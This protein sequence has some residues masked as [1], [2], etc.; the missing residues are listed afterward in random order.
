MS[1][2]FVLKTHQWHMVF[3]RLIKFHCQ[4]LIKC[5]TQYNIFWKLEDIIQIIYMYVYHNKKGNI[6]VPFLPNQGDTKAE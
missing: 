6:K 1:S 5:N 3:G 4:E 2:L